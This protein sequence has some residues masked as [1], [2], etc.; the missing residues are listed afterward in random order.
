MYRLLVQHSTARQA[1][2]R[3]G[4]P[5]APTRLVALVDRPVGPTSPAVTRG[6]ALHFT[7]VH[8]FTQS[9]SALRCHICAGT[10]RTRPNLRR[11]CGSPRPHLRRYC[12]ALRRNASVR[13]AARQSL[14]AKGLFTVPGEHPWYVSTC[15]DT[16]THLALC[17]IFCSPAAAG[18]RP[19]PHPNAHT[20]AHPTLRRQMRSRARTHAPGRAR[21]CA[22]WASLLRACP[23]AVAST[24]TA[25]AWCAGAAA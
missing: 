7:F 12:A 4:T 17:L 20:R 14:L 11:D 6:A 24:S 3:H 18:F 21:R 5:S 10:G 22:H 23:T 15:A 19:A 8:S 16:R 25:A 9:R 13:E 1:P 2:W